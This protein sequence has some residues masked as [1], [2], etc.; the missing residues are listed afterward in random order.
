MWYNAMMKWILLSPFHGL[1][2]KGII[3]ITYTGRKSRKAYSL[4]V[5]YVRDGDVIYVTSYRARTWWRSLRGGAAVSV[6][7]DGG[8]RKA[9]GEVIEDDA[10]VAEGLMAY[11]QKVPQYA[12]YYQ[13]KLDPDGTPDAT[14]ITQASRDRVFIRLHLAP[15]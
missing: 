6:R 4:P 9:R 8:D 11:L 14:D 5:N 12:K 7:L 10:G 13:V 15:V 1:I 2:S 3:L